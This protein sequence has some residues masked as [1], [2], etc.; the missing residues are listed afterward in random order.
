MVLYIHRGVPNVQHVNII[1]LIFPN[2][3]VGGEPHENSSSFSYNSPLEP[4][5]SLF[6]LK[7]RLVHKHLKICLLCFPLYA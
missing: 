7:N 6:T 1:I 5:D 4:Q 2:K 3:T